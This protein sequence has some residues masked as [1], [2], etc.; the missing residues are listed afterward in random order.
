MLLAFGD[1]ELVGLVVI[2]VGRND[3]CGIARLD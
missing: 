3:A 2:P 1:A